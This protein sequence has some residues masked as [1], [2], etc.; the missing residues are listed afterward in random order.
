MS[1]VEIPYASTPR[2]DTG[3]SNAALAMW[4]FIASEIMLFGALF[5]SYALLRIGNP[6]W[7]DQQVLLNGPLAAVNTL[8]LILSSVAITLAARALAAGNTALFRATSAISIALGIGFLG[9]KAFEYG[10]EIRGGLLPATNNFLGLY[11]VMTGLHALHVVAGLGVNGYFLATLPGLQARQPAK[12]TSRMRQCALYWN[13][14]DLVW[15][16]MFVVLYLL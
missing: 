8:V 4:L 12:A 2:P 14:I 1:H 16:T 11:Y 7:P 13:F 10:A 15:I 6:S 9:V 5:S 3:V